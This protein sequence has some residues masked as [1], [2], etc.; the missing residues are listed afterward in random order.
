MATLVSA[1][2]V[3]VPAYLALIEKGY[4]VKRLSPAKRGE[5]EEWC[6][7]KGRSRFLAED[8]LSLLG[9]VSLYEVRGRTWRAS[10]TELESF[11][12]QFP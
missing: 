5:P 7:T 12:E 10:D 11:F 2:N 6:A 1:S 3:L 4:R 9:L 8:T